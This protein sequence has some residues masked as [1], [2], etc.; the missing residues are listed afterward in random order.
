MPRYSYS[1]EDGTRVTHP[2][3]TEDFPDDKAAMDHAWKVAR[4]FSGSLSAMGRSSVVVRNETDEEVGSVP[5][6]SVI[7]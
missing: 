2:E 1:L 7:R 5:L 4:D 3:A 6:V